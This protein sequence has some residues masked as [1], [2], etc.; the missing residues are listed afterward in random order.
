ME[1]ARL[2]MVT[3]RLAK[4]ILEKNIYNRKIS[5]STVNLYAQQMEQGKWKSGTL[6]YVKIATDGSVL[7]GQHRLLAII[8]SDTC[9]QLHVAYNMDK[10]LFD[11]LDTGKAR[12][13]AD[14][15]SI[16]KI[17]NPLVDSEIVRVYL[18]IEK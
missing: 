15:F 17:E 14:V 16:A 6:E 8:Q 5:K 18:L 2:V 3:P 7:D 1:N 11:V 4:E 10:S 9:Q 12:N 13:S